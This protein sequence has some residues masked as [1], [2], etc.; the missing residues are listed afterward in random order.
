[1]L[2]SRLHIRN[3]RGIGR[4]DLDLAPTT[5]IIGENNCGKTSVLDAIAIALGKACTGAHCP[6]EALDFHRPPGAPADH[7]PEPIRI[8][9][10]LA[11]RNAGEWSEVLVKPYGAAVQTLRD[12]RRVLRFQVV[13]ERENAPPV[14]RFLDFDDRPVEGVDHD[15]L[16]QQ[17]PRGLRALHFGA[18]R[19]L[20]SDVHAALRADRPEREQVRRD[21][22]HALYESLV[23]PAAR[24]PEFEAELRRSGELL[25]LASGLVDQEQSSDRITE[26]LLSQLGA[27]TTDSG[28]EMPL[29][30]LGK[31]TQTIMLL[32]LLGSMLQVATVDDPLPGAGSLVALEDPEAHLHPRLVASLW[33]VV[34]GMR[35][36]RL[37]VTHSGD[38]LAAIP[39]ESI[40]VLRRRGTTIETH[41][42][43]RSRLTPDEIRRVAYHVVN[44]RG[45]RS[46]RHRVPIFCPSGV[47]RGAP[48]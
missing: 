37:V 4:I 34:E 47:A 5:V 32:L 6:F 22:F 13:G 48:A 41:A 20:W 25:S 38:F 46:M 39:I 1:M 17:L 10:E 12:G 26:L 43:S 44:R 31:G 42:L 35:A 30:H 21:R 28:A 2:L 19:T 27:I 36:Q 9:L 24:T 16:A 33:R 7:K 14:R 11:E 45:T 40:R 29:S 15:A 8:V 18:H 23:D 3:F